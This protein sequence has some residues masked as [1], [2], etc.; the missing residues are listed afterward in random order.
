MTDDEILSKATSIE[1]DEEDCE[2]TDEVEELIQPPTKYELMQALEVLK[3][4][5]F[6]D[7][8]V[9]DEMRAKINAFSKLYDISMTKTK[10]QNAITDF[11]VHNEHIKL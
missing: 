10:R 6:Y 1:K 5:T 11:F 4:C 2:D 7:A 3:T 9:R 8:A